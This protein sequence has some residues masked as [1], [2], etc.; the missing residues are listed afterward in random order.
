MLLALAFFERAAGQIEVVRETLWYQSSDGSCSGEATSVG[1]TSTA[2][3]CGQAYQQ[4]VANGFNGTWGVCEP[5]TGHL[6][7]YIE[8][9]HETSPTPAPIEPPEYPDDCG[10]EPGRLCFAFE[11]GA[12][13][14]LPSQ[15]DGFIDNL[16]VD[17]NP[18]SNSQDT[19]F[20][21]LL[22]TP[23]MGLEEVD[24]PTSCGAGVLHEY[25]T[26]EWILPLGQCWS[27]MN[28]N[29]ATPTVQSNEG[30]ARAFIAHCTDEG[31]L[32]FDEYRTTVCYPED[33]I[34]RTT[35]AN[36]QNSVGPITSGDCLNGDRTGSYYE[37]ISDPTAGPDF[38][39]G[40]TCDE[41]DFLGVI[42]GNYDPNQDF[43]QRCKK[44]CGSFPNCKFFVTNSNGESS[45]SG[46]LTCEAYR[47]CTQK[48][49]DDQPPQ[50]GWKVYQ[51]NFPAPGTIN[52]TEPT[53]G[54]LYYHRA[55]YS[56]Q[57]PHVRSPQTQPEDE[58]LNLTLILGIAIPAV[59][60]CLLLAEW[61]RRRNKDGQPESSSEDKDDEKREQAD[62]SPSLEPMSDTKTAGKKE[63]KTKGWSIFGMFTRKDKSKTKTATKTEK[64][65]GV[66]HEKTSSTNSQSVE[67]TDRPAGKRPTGLKVALP[68]QT[69]A[70]PAQ[71]RGWTVQTPDGPLLI[72]P[73]GRAG[74]P[75][76][77]VMSTVPEATETRGHDLARLGFQSPMAAQQA[78]VAQQNRAQPRGTNVQNLQVALPQSAQPFSPGGSLAVVHTPNGPLLVE[79]TS[80]A[81]PSR[82]QAADYPAQFPQVHQ[83]TQAAYQKNE[84]PDLQP[85]VV[86]QQRGQQADY[87]TPIGTNG[88]GGSYDQRTPSRTPGG[89]SYGQ[90]TPQ[91]Q[92]WQ[93]HG[94]QQPGTHPANAQQRGTPQGGQTRGSTVQNLRVSVQGNQQAARSRT[95][96]ASYYSARDQRER[97]QQAQ[98]ERNRR[99]SAPNIMQG[100]Y[101]Q[102]HQRAAEQQYAE[103]QQA[104]AYH[105][106]QA[107]AVDYRQAAAV[108]EHLQQRPVE[109]RE[110]RRP[111]QQ[112]RV[113][114]P[115]PQRA[116]P[117][118]RASPNHG[119]QLHPYGQP[120]P[121]GRA[122]Q[123]QANPPPQQRG[124]GQYDPR[125]AQATPYDPRAAAQAQPPQQ[126]AR[127]PQPRGHQPQARS[128]AGARMLA[129]KH[130]P[131]HWKVKDVQ[132]WL[133][134]E[135]LNNL[136]GMQNN[137]MKNMDGVDL[138]N[139]GYGDLISKGLQQDSSKM[140]IKYRD[141]FL[142]TLGMASP[143]P[144]IPELPFKAPAT[145]PVKQ[146][147]PAP[148]VSSQPKVNK[149]QLRHRKAKNKK[150]QVGANDLGKEYN[151][152]IP[153]PRSGNK[154]FS[155]APDWGYEEE[156]SFS[157][158]PRGFNMQ[159]EESSD[160]SPARTGR[161]RNHSV[162][163]LMQRQPSASETDMNG[164]LED[165]WGVTPSLGP[166]SNP[167]GPA[168]NL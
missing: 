93:Q 45:A 18:I 166:Q 118:T 115:Q 25:P 142:A 107:A 104:A 149:P 131:R 154:D 122:P 128:Q 1:G 81:V 21:K 148:V 15:P 76:M 153:P 147:R 9:C 3:S 51:V 47:A 87:H 95:P 2:A 156:P 32:Y 162:N 73:D 112:N 68:G 80:T 14:P 150:E 16:A 44:F 125:T 88:S 146:L 94:Y 37:T 36:I 152:G 33:K 58:G 22:T 100:H 92:E 20:V 144:G 24:S 4:I 91:G 86:P 167:W 79:L 74:L 102:S 11:G 34:R 42:Y 62:D 30:Q 129:P 54:L 70:P 126:S 64:E 40:Q 56:F 67:L 66:D 50:D 135:G 61:H 138:I 134:R 136:P 69:T 49:R 71:T 5:G 6:K 84:R 28:M 145:A 120:D 117:H 77:Q 106:Q 53:P 26:V 97:E 82:G 46:E 7:D 137:P 90:R 101:G 160:S 55:K 23:Y 111:A 72:T 99:G 163:D 83:S 124:G 29:P 63:S 109:R 161:P 140:V 65:A 114:E 78:L 143:R 133:S 159:H 127:S 139:M 12:C 60:I 35:P 27:H 8:W 39:S 85:I 103:Y 164:V 110:F 48:D 157:E 155:D 105:G 19:E 98:R 119:A 151:Y 158:Q 141:A 13:H 113:P 52:P 96:H 121:R 41:K 17:C 31:Q 123:A 10:Q 89:G 108:A 132:D 168:Q 75:A 43:A 57:C 130:D 38:V 165:A 59:V 116:S